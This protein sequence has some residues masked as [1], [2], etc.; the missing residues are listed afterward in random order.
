MGMCFSPES[1]NPSPYIRKGT[2]F[3]D[4]IKLTISGWGNFPRACG[5]VFINGT[6]GGQKKRCD[7]CNDSGQ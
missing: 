5:W 1:E 2:L 3:G 7:E 6:H 4:V